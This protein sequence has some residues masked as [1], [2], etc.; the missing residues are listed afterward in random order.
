[1]LAVMLE[2]VAIRPAAEARPAPSVRELFLGFA[3]IS[4]SGYGGVLAWAQRV[5]VEERGWMTQGEF[6]E[7][8]SLCQILPGPNIVNFSVIFGARS[9]GPGGSL[10]ALGGLLGPPVVLAVAL[11]ALYN[12]YGDLPVLRNILA[13]VTAAAGGFL[14]ATT[15]KLGRGLFTGGFTAAPVVAAAGF[16]TVGV[17]RWPLPWVLCVLLPASVFVAWLA[18]RSG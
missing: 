1:M 12:A 10:A 11:A 16:V 14:V 8:F 4:L 7:L 9:C 18:R 15:I 2:T 6:N 3:K 13:G 17:M 5:I